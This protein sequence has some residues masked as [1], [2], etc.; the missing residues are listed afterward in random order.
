MPHDS[1]EVKPSSIVLSSPAAVFWKEAVGGNM[2]ASFCLLCFGACGWGAHGSAACVFGRLL[3]SQAVMAREE[4]RAEEE[5][6]IYTQVLLS[7]NVSHS[8]VQSWREP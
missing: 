8:V 5:P 4:R 2:R 1:E 7:T 3:I 6:I